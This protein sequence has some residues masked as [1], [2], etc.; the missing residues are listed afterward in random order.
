MKKSKTKINKQNNILNLVQGPDKCS[1]LDCSKFLYPGC[2]RSG[3]L[4]VELEPPTAAVARRKCA[5]QIAA[6]GTTTKKNVSFQQQYHPEPTF[7][8]NHGRE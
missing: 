3:I 7:L 8:E 4:C 1:G 5:S 2:R 6:G